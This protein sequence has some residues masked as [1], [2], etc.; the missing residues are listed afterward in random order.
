MQFQQFKQGDVFVEGPREVSEAEILEFARRY[1]PQPFHIDKEFA[2]T[3]RW[4]TLIAS[5][6]MTCSIAMELAARLLRGS[7]SFG[8]PGVDELRWEQP[9]RPGD[10]LT[11]RATI[12]QTRVS[13]SGA[14]GILRWQ[15]ELH[16]Q[17]EARVLVLTATS[18]F[19]V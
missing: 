19:G 5:G 17:D 6:W 12:L 7:T 14:I 15:W 2:A 11:L 9:V 18:F 13:S 16:N 4:G 8:S 10:Q 1:D 3:S